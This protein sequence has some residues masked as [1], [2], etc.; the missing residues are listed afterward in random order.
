MQA[1]ALVCTPVINSSCDSLKSVVTSGCVSAEPSGAG[2]GVVASVPSGR[3]RRLSFSMPRLSPASTSRGSAFT[4][5]TSIASV[6]P[7]VEDIESP[8]VGG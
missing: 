8:S 7:V 2:C 4:R 3:T 1:S 6:E 5:S